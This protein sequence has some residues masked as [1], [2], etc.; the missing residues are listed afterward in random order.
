MLCPYQQFNDAKFRIRAF[1]VKNLEI[2][3]KRAFLTRWFILM[4]EWKSNEFLNIS[5]HWFYFKSE[6][7]LNEFLN[8]YVHW[9]K[10]L[11]YCITLLNPLTCTSG[12]KES[13]EKGRKPVIFVQNLLFSFKILSFLHALLFDKYVRNMHTTCNYTWF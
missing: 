9:F 10:Q 6:W 7:K 8:V 13:H 3:L 5:V 4:S 11:F 12:G 1:Y 2:K